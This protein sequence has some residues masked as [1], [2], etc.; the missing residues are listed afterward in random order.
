V[1][2]AKLKGV[3][4]LSCSNNGNKTLSTELLSKTYPTKENTLKGMLVCWES[5]KSL[6]NF[7]DSVL[8]K[9]LLQLDPY[10][11]LLLHKLSTFLNPDLPNLEHSLFLH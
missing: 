3:N 5:R 10:A 6:P 11:Q 4:S 1:S 8:Q 7:K 2:L 9:S